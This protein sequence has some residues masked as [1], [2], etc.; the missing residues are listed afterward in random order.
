[1]KAPLEHSN[2]F[3]ATM[4]WTGLNCDTQKPSEILFPWKWSI[5]VVSKY[6]MNIAILLCLVM[7]GSDVT[8]IALKTCKTC[9][10]SLQDRLRASFRVFQSNWWQELFFF[11]I[12][13]ALQNMCGFSVVL[14]TAENILLSGTEHTIFNKCFLAQETCAQKRFAMSFRSIIVQLPCP[15]PWDFSPVNNSGLSNTLPK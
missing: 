5:I 9:W 2:T 4:N 12:L 13:P 1:M 15:F 8:L 14:V 10:G 3:S 11:K 6:L 7:S